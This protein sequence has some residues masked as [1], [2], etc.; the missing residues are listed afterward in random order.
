MAYFSND[1]SPTFY[2]VKAVPECDIY[3]L[4]EPWPWS[5]NDGLLSACQRALSLES[6]SELREKSS[7]RS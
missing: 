6:F 5:G 1:K 4:V 3:P 7:H 2:M